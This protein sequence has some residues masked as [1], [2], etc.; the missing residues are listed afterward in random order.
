ME[1][2]KLG[3]YSRGVSI[4][5]VGATPFFNVLDNPDYEGITEAELFA[6]A[7]KEA[8]EDCGLEG[9]DIDF[10]YHGEC[11]PGA[12]SDYMT[13]NMQIAEWLGMR[14]KGSAHH[15]E[16][17]CTG[18]VAL[19][20]AVNAVASGKY[21]IVLTGCA[22]MCDSIFVRGKP[23]TFRD[24]LGFVDLLNV[25]PQSADRAYTRYMGA[26]GIHFD[27]AI[28]EYATKYGLSD[29]QVDDVLNALAIAAR[30]NSSVNERALF[31]YT[32]DVDA[33]E[34]GFDS[35]EE[36][37][38]SDCNPHI[39]QY[40]RASGGEK[41]C[42]GGA[43]CIVCPTEMAYQFTDKPIEVLGIGHSCLEF[44]QPNLERRATE[45]AIAQVYE[46]TG[47]G[48][49]DIDLLLCNDF[50]IPSQLIAAEA[51]GYLPKGEGW[52]YILEGRTTY[53]GDRPMNTNGGRC[54]YG[55]AY[56]AS[57][58]AD[59]YEAVKQLRGEA[60]AHQIKKAPKHVMLR[61]FGGGQNVAATIL[62]LA[63]KED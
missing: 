16:G 48:P 46:A 5:G 14:G 49:D 53:D 44:A 22:E 3:K 52:K 24:E 58:L 54:A 6:Y 40:L 29:D 55:H 25:L 27:I 9:K 31:Q 62:K 37:L 47:L 59:T 36:F 18:Y 42:C 4:I 60:G 8:M 28:R 61:G 38:K 39:G 13:P 10:F 56:A 50:F 20:M 17:C 45:Q 33:E 57:G 51:A 21:D 34:Y 1:T 43:A 63:K 26:Y 2:V 30:K 35:A 32:Y 19:D 12:L 11:F 15:S 7:A 41:T 23:A